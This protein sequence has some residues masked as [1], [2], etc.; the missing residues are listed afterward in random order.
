LKK[1]TIVKNLLHVLPMEANKSEILPAKNMDDCLS[2]STTDKKNGQLSPSLQVFDRVGF[3]NA[4]VNECYENQTCLPVLL[5]LAFRYFDVLGIPEKS[6]QLYFEVENAITVFLFNMRRLNHLLSQYSGSSQ[7]STPAIE[8]LIEKYK[9]HRTN[10]QIILSHCQW[11]Y[12]L[13]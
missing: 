9:F 3:V 2:S 12:Q 13:C 6:T 5:L 4:L 11:Q 10:T 1:D 7:F 8:H